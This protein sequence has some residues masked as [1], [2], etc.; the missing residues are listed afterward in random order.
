MPAA[1]IVI[2]MIA[3]VRVAMDVSVVVGIDVPVVPC[4]GVARFDVARNATIHR[5]GAAVVGIANDAS[6]SRG[7]P[8]SGRIIRYTLP[9][10]G[11]I[12]VVMIEHRAPAALCASPGVRIAGRGVLARPRATVVRIVA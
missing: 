6:L 11:I 8:P 5:G 12:A 2:E 10:G 1:T 3:R 4:D 9:P 7:K